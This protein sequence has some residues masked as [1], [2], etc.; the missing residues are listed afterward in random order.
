MNIIESIIILSLLI[1]ILQ[2]HFDI[3]FIFAFLA[4]KLIIKLYDFSNKFFTESEFILY[5]NQLLH[6]TLLFSFV[7]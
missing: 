2:Y 7:R 3:S 1:F 5:I 4:N 6:L